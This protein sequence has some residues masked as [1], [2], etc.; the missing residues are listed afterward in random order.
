GLVS[1]IRQQRVP[2]V[3]NGTR[4]A[5]LIHVDNLVEAILT[6]VHSD[7]GWGERYFINEL[8]RF[9]WIDFFAAVRDMVGVDSEFINVQPEARS[10]Q[11]GRESK[12]GIGDTLKYFVSGEF[13]KSMSA[14]PAFNRLNMTIY[15]WFNSRNPDF[16][17]W[18][19][20]RLERPVRISKESNQPT[21]DKSL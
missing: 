8:T 10:K 7:H 5:N 4:T 20:R 6:A 16:Q 18:V 2:I 9:R 3:E 14:I 13:R 1:A 12:Y 15:E 19:R 17:K 11:Q 21:V